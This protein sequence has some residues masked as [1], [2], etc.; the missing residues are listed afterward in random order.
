MVE[1]SYNGWV[2]S[3]TAAGLPGGL[4]RLTV[5]GELFAPGVRAGDVA[6]VLG[7]VA[8]QLHAR[9]E[10]V[11]RDD[12][13]QADD[14]GWNYRTNRNAN[15]L[16]SHASGTA[17]DYNATRHPNDRRGTFTAAQ[18]REI[19][20]ILAEVQNA[21][22]WGGDFT[23]TKDEMHWEVQVG[24]ATLA[25]VADSL[26]SR[27]VLL[28]GSLDQSS[29]PPPVPVPPPPADA[30]GVLE[31]GEAGP[32]VLAWQVELWRVGYGVGAHDGLYGDATTTQTTLLQVASWL[33]PD[34]KAGPVTRD[35]AGRV[36]DY[37]KPA[38][39]GMTWAERGG[40]A[41]AA[42]AFQQRLHDRGWTI[43]VDGVWG[44][45]SEDVCSQFQR[46]ARLTPD[47]VGGPQ[48]WT[49]LHVLPIT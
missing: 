23:G 40:D 44:P 30:D 1:R 26:R 11:V 21:V 4:E 5:A 37:P 38:G 25:R 3:R 17:I 22:R 36:P 49:A 2:A 42:R 16:S 27:T 7:Y 14:W 24:E 13:H 20:V 32:A 15:N 31:L 10:P 18:V 33:D 35:A 34:G 46:Q 19:R 8:R 45:R 47:G 39:P 29:A 43:T 9:V 41:G 48:V 28:G 6:T 12:W